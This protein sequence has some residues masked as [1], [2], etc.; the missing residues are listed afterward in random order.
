VLPLPFYPKVWQ[1]ME[2]KRETPPAAGR[3]E[4]R[5]RQRNVHFV[6]GRLYF[7]AAGSVSWAL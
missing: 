2:A 1:A 7:A 4:L 3:V 6:V 5:L